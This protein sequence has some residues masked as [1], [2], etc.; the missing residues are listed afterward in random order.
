MSV[1]PSRK[2]NRA[3][4]ILMGPGGSSSIRWTCF[5]FL[6]MKFRL[7]WSKIIWKR[8]MKWSSSPCLFSIFDPLGRPTVSAGSDQYFRTYFRPCVHPSFQNIAKQN[9][10]GVKIMIATA[11]TAD[12][13]EWIID[14]TCLVPLFLLAE[15]GTIGFRKDLHVFSW[16]QKLFRIIFLLWT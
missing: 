9:K 14:D 11:G 8:F 16:V 12:L 1:H 13:A 10:R 6:L 5:Y 4:A 15:I 7:W 2:Q 3:I